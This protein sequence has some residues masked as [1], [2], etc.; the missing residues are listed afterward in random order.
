MAMIH[1]RDLNLEMA[2]ILARFTSQNWG[3]KL[4][5]GKWTRYDTW[6]RSSIGR[7]SIRIRPSDKLIVAMATFGDTHMRHR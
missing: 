7:V 5:G 1:L 3:G 4:A 2:V 6:T